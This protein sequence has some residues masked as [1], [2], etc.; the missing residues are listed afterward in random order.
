MKRKTLP[1]IAR[2]VGLP[3]KQRLHHFLTAARWSN[4]HLQRRRLQLIKSM[5]AD[6][7]LLL[8]IDETGDRK[9]GQTTDY[10]AKQYIGNIGKTA[11][12]IV[13]VNAYGVVGNITY[14]LLFK[15]FK[16][17]G[18]LQGED[19]YRTKIQL[20]VEIIET[21]QQWGFQFERVLADIVSMAKVATLSGYSA[22]SSGRSLWQFFPIMGCS[23]RRDKECATTAFEPSSTRWPTA[24][25]SHDSSER[26]SSVNGVSCGTFKS[27]KERYR[28]PRRIAGTS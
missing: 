5:V 24:R 14:P 4:D 16:P 8:I 27:R 28:M 18:R 7:P 11:N 12:G 26:L 20:A 15:V 10:V 23:C 19:E 9:K 6:Q 21:L 25:P 1:A 13:S 22:A 3:D 17:K 2:L